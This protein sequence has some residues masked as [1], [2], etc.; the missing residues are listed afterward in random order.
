LAAAT[1]TKHNREF[2]ILTAV[3]SANIVK[4][5]I[6]HKEEKIEELK[7]ALEKVEEVKKMVEDFKG[8]VSKEQTKKKSTKDVKVQCCSSTV[9]KGIQGTVGPAVRS[10]EK[11]ISKR[12]IGTQVEQE[13]QEEERVDVGEPQ[14]V[15]PKGIEKEVEEAL[16]RV[17]KKLE[18]EKETQVD[19]STWSKV[20]GR[21]K[22]KVKEIPP[23]VPR[24]RTAEKRKRVERSEREE[25]QN[26]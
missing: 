13:Q 9:E 11:T 1:D 16:Y 22:K 25:R 5:M 19:T 21:R 6:A 17:L 18:E 3:I 8:E 12:N 4:R 24:E 10:I 26:P 14:G 23:Q 20:L 15:N 2:K 7:R